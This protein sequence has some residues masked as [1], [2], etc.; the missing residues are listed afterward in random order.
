MESLLRAS[1]PHVLTEF[2][3]DDIEQAGAVPVDVL[4]LYREWGY[5][6]V[7]VTDEVVEAAESGKFAATSAEGSNEALVEHAR[8]TAGGFVTLWLR[9][10]A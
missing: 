5:Q 8:S 10:L 2:D 7:P 4:A 1:R 9:P 3:P 6:L